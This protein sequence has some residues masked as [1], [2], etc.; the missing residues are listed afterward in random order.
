MIW[1]KIKTCMISVWCTLHPLNKTVLPKRNFKKWA[2]CHI[3]KAAPHISSLLL[4]LFYFQWS[5]FICFTEIFII[6]SRWSSLFE[7]FCCNT[8]LLLWCGSIM[9]MISWLIIDEL[10]QVI[11]PSPYKRDRLPGLKWRFWTGLHTHTHTHTH[12]GVSSCQA[13]LIPTVAHTST[14]PQAPELFLSILI[15]VSPL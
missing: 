10:F 7:K 13:L 15:H 2:S 6:C 1:E 8:F 14:H 3:K 12:S 9:L 11:H 4:I 5:D